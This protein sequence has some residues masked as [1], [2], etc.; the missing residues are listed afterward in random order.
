MKLRR[1]DIFQMALI[2]SG[3]LVAIL[4]S[5]FLYREIYPE[6]KIYQEDYLAL[7]KFRSTY[8]GEPVPPFS[9]GVKQIV[10]ERED[11]GPAVV[12]RCVS[13]H[14]ALEI[15]AFSPTQVSRNEKGDIVYNK[16]GYPVLEEN[17]NF[18]WKKLDQAIADLRD[19]KVNENLRQQG[20]ESKVNQRL[21]Q[22]AQYEAL[23]TAHVGEHVYDVKRV[24]SMHPLIGK[25]TRP[26]EFHP[27]AEYGCTSCHNGNGN[28]LVTDKAHGP[29]F[30]EQYEVEFIGEVP[31]FLEKDEVN[32]PR[33]SKVF[34][35]KPGH[36]LLFQ[37]TPIYV[38]SLIQAKCVQCHQTLQDQRAIGTSSGLDPLVQKSVDTLTKNYQRGRELFIEQAC[39]AC[40]K[41]AA[42]SRGGVG[43]ELTNEGDSYPWYIKQKISWPQSDLKTSTMP[44]MRI[45]HEELEDLMTFILAQKGSNKAVGEIPYKAAV[46]AWDEGRKLPWEKSITPAEIYDLNYS[47][48]VFATEGCAACHRLKGFESNVGYA[49]EKGKPSFEQLS[50]E[51]E[52][53]QKLFP[54]TIMGSQIVSVIDE[55]AKEIDAKIVN[56]VRQNAILEEIEKKYP[57]NLESFYSSFKYAM[58]SK[59]DAG[60]SQ[61]ELN[62]WK[63]RVKRV[64]MMFIQEYGLGRLIC[65]RPNW[66]GVYRT[67]EWLME[68]FRNPASLVPR[69]LMPAFPFDDTKF[70]ALTYLLDMLGM[71]NRDANREVWDHRG[72]NPARAFDLYCSQCH[73]DY[74][75]GNGP[76]AEWIYPIPKNLSSAEFLRN[77]TKEN[78]IMSIHHGIKGTP[79]PPWG[80]VGED[81]PLSVKS[82]SSG[83]PILTESEIKQL[84]DWLFSLIPEGD[85]FKGESDVMKWQYTPEDAIKELEREGNTEKLKSEPEKESRHKKEDVAALSPV[86]PIVGTEE[87][88]VKDFF[89]EVPHTVV[90]EPSTMYYIKKK[91]YTEHNIKE[92]QKFF[93]ANCAVCHGN[94]G[95]GSGLR[96]GTMSEAK[97]QMLTNLNWIRT[98]DDLRLLRSIKYGIPGTA[99]T[100][101]GDFT[102]S[103]LRM[104]LVIFIRTLTQEQDQRAKLNTALYETFSTALQTIDAARLTQSRLI[105]KQQQQF[106]KALTDYQQATERAEKG[107][108]PL[109]DAVKAYELYLSEGVHL[110]REQ[111]LDQILINLKTDIQQERE[112]Y[113]KI[114]IDLINAGLGDE[115]LDIVL[116]MIALNKTRFT[117]DKNQLI[118]KESPQIDQKLEMLT[119]QINEILSNKMKRLEKEQLG[120]EGQL[121]SAQRNEELREING[122]INTYKG[123]KDKIT[124]YV[125]EAIEIKAKEK[126]LYEQLK[127]K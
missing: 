105:Q 94:E 29:V 66:S 65:P 49:I 11:K 127:K 61:K 35:G 69:S 112:I 73:G 122:E 96:A 72:F 19:E 71:R 50:E 14:V 120:V 23:K 93:L 63:A 51:H 33:F 8:T 91:Y 10:L 57:N 90:D 115:A 59:N 41:I 85:I 16:E 22:A 79:M 6:Y 46:K 2:L 88:Q 117:V 74:R 107:A 25:E 56:D 84:V 39:Y 77:L 83:K 104:Q 114:G 53:F 100:P 106:D 118:F 113:Q 101:W 1:E 38:G 87:L 70:Y 32:D 30:D 48:M 99:M 20:E 102:S 21:A 28:G 9:M 37:T 27:V 98:R 78:A 121:A 124:Q 17:K 3:L 44:N 42:L 81:K 80:E 109:V 110:N 24:L 55:H 89:D 97:P 5:V 18:I 15:P 92:G 54:E 67:D 47:M 123:L 43:P 111:A 116:Q 62:R 86:F 103:L 26:F 60:L 119:K 45:D 125:K 7:E 36:G 40:H 34:N 58:R 52:W 4:F 82:I 12:D 64:M 95:D 75:Q 108:V 126:K 76:V 68:H 31:Q 13:C